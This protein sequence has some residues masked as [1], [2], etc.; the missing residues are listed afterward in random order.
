MSVKKTGIAS[1]GIHFPSL[2]M[3]VEELA[4]LRHVDP[5]KFMVGLGC[6]KIALCPENYNIVDLATEAARRA[7]SRWKGDLSNIALIAVGTESAIDMSRPLSAWVADNLNLKGAVRSYEV[8]H[9]CYGGTL[10]VRQACEWRMSGVAKGKAALV[11]AADI[12]MYAQGDPGEP[13]QGA[14]AV[15]LI[16]DEPLIAE[17]EP[18][19]YPWS[20]PAFDFWR[21]NG[22]KFPRVAGQLS[23]E[24]YQKAAT[25]CF[26][27]LIAGR[28]PEEVL[29]QYHALCFHVPFPKMVRKAFFSACQA[30]GWDDEKI[31]KIY[32]AKIEPTMAWNKL[33]G[34]AYTAS[35]WIAVANTLC[36]LE[37]GKLITAFS[38]GSGFG[39]EL[40]TLKAGPLAQEGKWAED[41]KKDLEERKDIDA[42]EY[43]E[44]RS[45]ANEKAR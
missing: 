30:L 39:A 18:D 9:A 17:I 35:L 26:R 28:D 42:E 32:S 40:L 22:E 2:S 25:Q 33:S 10:A 45:G 14:G 4:K 38:Y 21:P 8:K 11:I 44:L 29:N 24:C 16:I 3:T 37:S 20:E 5:N 23:L 27:A 41:I 15:A 31:E 12:A 1:I 13:T 36:G 19:S 6:S 34:N 43:E 7:L